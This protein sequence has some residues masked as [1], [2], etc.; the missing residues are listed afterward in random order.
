MTTRTSSSSSA[1]SSDSEAS[2]RKRNFSETSRDASQS[3][4]HVQATSATNTIDATSI[5]ET[6]T[7]RSV[8][9]PASHISGT[10]SGGGTAYDS[11]SLATTN[12]TGFTNT[13]QQQQQL[14]S[15]I[16]IIRPPILQQ[17]TSTGT[18]VFGPQRPTGY[19]TQP[20]V[21]PTNA[22][23]QQPIRI[24]VTA[25]QQQYQQHGH[26]PEISPYTGSTTSTSGG[27]LSSPGTASIQQQPHTGTTQNIPNQ[28]N[29][30]RINLNH[31]QE[32]QQQ[33]QGGFNQP[34]G[35]YFHQQQQQ[36]Q[37]TQPAFFPNQIPAHQV[38]NE[39]L[40]P[41]AFKDV[42]LDID[43]GAMGGFNAAFSSGSDFSGG[44]LPPGISV[45]PAYTTV[46]SLNFQQHMFN[47][48]R[49]THAGGENF[50]FNFGSTG[51]DSNI[52]G[53]GD[54]FGG[55]QFDVAKA[56]FNQADTNRDGSISR[57]EFQ[58]W[59]QGGQQ[60]IGG[61]S[62]STTANYQTNVPSYTGSNDGF[63]Q[64]TLFD[65]ADPTIANILQ[66]SGLGQVVPNQ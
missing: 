58:Q 31:S 59:A 47:T 29:L 23:N 27:S 52:G 28:V 64:A 14:A 65:G 25:A 33:T 26:Q 35:Q 15:G 50:N 20:P 17:Q 54:I 21:V 10:A 48:A 11:V 30:N 8:S 66:Q 22:V 7:L 13:S 61:Q 32:F 42:I 49:T 45:R 44:Q 46:D 5:A 6:G 3:E 34:H 62:Y 2:A 43:Y 56:M 18:G 41:D 40:G 55:Q 1:A 4:S 16:P 39:L 57:D 36:Q 60:N 53:T 51:I 12:N 38:Y 63:Y 24:D 37:Q 19:P 9:S